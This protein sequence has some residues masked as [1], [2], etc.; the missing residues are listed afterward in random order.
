MAKDNGKI[1]T[2]QDLLK[3]LEDIRNECEDEQIRPWYRGHACREWKLIPKGL[4]GKKN[5]HTRVNLFRAEAT[6]IRSNPPPHDDL[7]QW[8]FLMQHHGLPTFLLDWTRSPLVALYFALCENHD[9]KDGMLWA[10][11][12]GIWNL[13]S[14][15]RE[16]DEKNKYTVFNSYSEKLNPLFK[17]NFDRP[18]SSEK[19]LKK[20]V[21]AI[22]PVYN[23]PRMIAQQSVF[24]IHGRE[25]E[26]MEQLHIHKKYL[27][28]FSIP[29][30]KKAALR[31]NLQ[32]LGIL[33]SSL[34]P[35]LDNLSHCLMSRYGSTDPERDSNGAGGNDAQPENLIDPS[36]V[37]N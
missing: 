30:E 23:S 28:H 19:S 15:P 11:R 32:D 2:I 9:K 18:N 31:K 37:S 25:S 8:L 10:L 26:S 12:P 3:K 17:A 1:L 7:R 21:L 33:R 14:Y 20:K 13:C 24:T 6:A 34:F 29:N 27:R 5:L 22:Q 16:K 35:D 4:R 36:D